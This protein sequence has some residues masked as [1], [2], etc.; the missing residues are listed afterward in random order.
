MQMRLAILLRISYPLLEY[1]L[2]FLDILSVKINCIVW[3][4]SGRI[5]LPENVVGR[6]LIVGVHI[7]RMLLPLLA[8][9]M[10]RSSIASLVCLMRLQFEKSTWSSRAI[11]SETWATKF[12]RT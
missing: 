6:L 5:V 10:R 12:K 8:Q 3:N 2:R 7:R 9:L 11:G 1:R 4:P